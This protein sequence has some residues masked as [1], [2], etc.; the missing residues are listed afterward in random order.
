MLQENMLKRSLVVEEE[1]SGE[2]TEDELNEFRND[3][4]DDKTD[5]KDE[6]NQIPQDKPERKISMEKRKSESK[7]VMIKSTNTGR[8]IS[9]AERIFNM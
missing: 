6:D 9:D 2:D 5:K 1:S 4:T 7:S 3:L 8:R